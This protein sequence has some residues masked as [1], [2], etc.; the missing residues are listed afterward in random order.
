MKNDNF[1]KVSGRLGKRKSIQKKN[2]SRKQKEIPGD[3]SLKKRELKNLK[4]LFS[5][6][7]SGDKKHKRNRQPVTN[8]STQIIT[9][10]SL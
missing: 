1:I 6:R 8:I 2:K 4:K 10:F 3:T 7:T 9:S 5:S